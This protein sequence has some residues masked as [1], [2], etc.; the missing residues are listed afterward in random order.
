MLPQRKQLPS[1]RLY[2]EKIEMSNVFEANQADFA[3]KV[4]AR[5]HK[6]LVLVDFWAPWCG[7]CRMLG[8]TLERLANEAGSQFVLAKVNSDHNQQLSRQFDVRGIP[9]VKAFVNGRVVDEFVGALPEARVRQ[10]IQKVIATHQPQTKSQSQS[11]KPSGT[12]AE[13]LKKAHALLRQGQGCQAQTQLADLPSESLSEKGNRFLTLA[14]FICDGGQQMAGQSKASSAYQQAADA[15]RRRE[16]STALYNLLVA[17][18]QETDA[19]KPAVKELMEAIFTMLG[20]QN[21]L[22][23]QYRKLI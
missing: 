19:R 9:A 21:T 12:P 22:T 8:P 13:R 10:F 1:I 2:G 4:V 23:Q 5:S 11:T 17:Q 6:G 18:N 16:P 3:E 15:L 7:P 14:K 20:E